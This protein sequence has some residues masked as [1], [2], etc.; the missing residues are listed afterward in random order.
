MAK[1]GYS[2][3][4][5]MLVD[6]SDTS[7]EYLS[8]TSDELKVQA[9]NCSSPVLGWVYSSSDDYDTSSDGV[10]STSEISSDELD[11]DTI[12]WIERCTF[13]WHQKKVLAK[14][15]SSINNDPHQKKVC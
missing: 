4:E 1:K 15:C 7:I 14:T 3:D 9:A 5:G 2:S 13:M 8:S 6:S 10:S 12:K 11:D